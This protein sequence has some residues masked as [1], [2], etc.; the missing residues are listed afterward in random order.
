M[1]AGLQGSLRR[2]RGFFMID[3]F[4]YMALF[5]LVMGLAFAAFYRCLDF[6]RDLNR[7]AADIARTL[8][9]GENWRDDIRA[10]TATP[11]TVTEEGYT[12]LEIPQSSR[13][14]VYIFFDGAVWRKANLQTP[15]EMVLSGVKS[16][17]MERQPRR[18]LAAWSWAI[19][20]R[21]RKQFVRVPPLFNFLAV[22]QAD[23]NL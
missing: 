11:Q 2:E 20:L 5:G 10:A 4:I 15:M 12:A 19:E 9:A 18:Q 14:V 1:R 17:R 21:S 8:K 16:S 3:C 7:N 13:V 22:A 6:S 23:K